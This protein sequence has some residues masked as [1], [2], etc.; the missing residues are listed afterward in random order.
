MNE[1]PWHL[2]KPFLLVGMIGLLSTLLLMA[3]LLFSSGAVNRPAEAGIQATPTPI[4]PPFPTT[5]PDASKI[6][7]GDPDEEGYATVTGTAGAVPPDAAVAVINL[8]A[9]TLMTA[10]ANA[11]GGFSAT[12]YAPPGSSLLIKYDPK[13]D[14]IDQLWQDAQRWDDLVQPRPY[15]LPLPGMIMHVGA[16]PPGDGAQQSFQGAGQIPSEDGWVGRWISG[17]LQVSPG[18]TPPGFSLQPGDVATATVRVRITS[19]ALNCTTVPTYYVRAD[20]NLRYLFDA[21]GRAEAWGI[22]FNAHLFTPTGLPIEH[23]LANGE[24]VT[25]VEAKQL[26]S[27]ACVTPHAFDGLLVSTF[28]IPVDLPRG[29]YKIELDVAGDVPASQD[30]PF[31]SVWYYASGVSP[32]SV[33]KIGDTAPP[34]IPWTLLGDYPVNGHQGVQAREDVGHFAMPTRVLYP[35]HRVVIPRLDERTEQPLVYR[36]EPGSPWL[37]STERRHPNPPHIPFDLP[38]GHL[39]VEVFKPDG[40]VDQ[41]GPAPILQSSVRTPTLPDGNLLHEGTGNIGDL[42]HLTTMSD[43][44]VY[45]FDQYGDHVIRLYG[46]VYDIYGNPYPIERTYDVTVARVLDLDPAQLPTTPYEQG[47][48]FAPGLHVFPPVPADVTVQL[49]HMP[50]SDPDLAITSTITG[51]AN[52]FGY[53]QPSVGT[54]ITM[55]TPGEFRVDVSAVYTAADGTLWAGYMTWGNVVEG[56]GTQIVAHGRRG[57]TYASNTIDDMPAWFEGLSLPPQKIGADV[58][59]PYFSGDVHWGHEIEG[60]GGD[61]ISSV[62]TVEDLTPSRDIY[63]LLLA[64]Y[65]RATSGFRSPPSDISQAGLISRTLIGEA[66]LFI[67]TKSGMDAAVRPEDIDL[68]GYWY[69]SSERPDVRVREVVAEDGIGTVYWRFNDTYGYQIGEPADGDQPG[70][71]KWEFGGAVLRVISETNPINEYAIYSSMWVML[72]HGDTVGTRITA[73]FRGAN[74]T[75]IDGG[76]ILTMTIGGAAQEI[77]VLFL[78]K[79]VRPGDVLEVG[80]VIAFSGHVGPPLDSRVEVTITSPSGTPHLAVLCANKIGWVYDP[81]F[82][83]P[84]DEVGRWTVDVFVVHERPLAYAAAPASHNT[85]TVMGTTGRYEFYVVEPSSF[86]LPITAPQPGFIV[87]PGGKIEPI[88]IRG[89]IPAG[90]SEVRYTIHDKGVVMGQ[91]I[92]TPDA[93]GVFTVTYDA[94]AL[95]EDFSM[96]SLTAHEG[97]WEGLADEVTINLLA[98]GTAYPCANTVTLIGEEV[99]IG[100]DVLRHVYLPLVLRQ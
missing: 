40:S 91:G 81:G 63:D 16:P 55:T 54:A 95:H 88:Y 47:D 61:S 98:V 73:P 7:V 57:M 30:V 2:V 17:T 35:P 29:I 8:S 50:Y 62:V 46:E 83:F 75:T 60:M 34:R 5:P 82:D 85:G 19:P 6:A 84:A 93:F 92:V 14:L 64:Y 86:R 9:P 100:S 20:I 74:G 77:D 67:T 66:P 43:I 58:Y 18:G 76:P 97:R 48:A 96:L 94:E 37:S 42:Y 1:K 15:F 31:A 10:T 22:W 12:L 49:V 3:V 89:I 53:F 24:T 90:A 71:V 52:R 26:T 11:T 45:T 68:W 25:V 21:D 70:D 13:G 99:F 28:T 33:V 36:L 69:A 38:S 41:L 72:P 80:N 4:P 27:L 65:P 51:K 44:F 79:G 78:P 32:L 59:C 23:E 87:W 56:P 39:T